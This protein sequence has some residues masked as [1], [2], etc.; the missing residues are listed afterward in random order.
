M[1][2]PDTLVDAFVWPLRLLG[3]GPEEEQQH[4]PLLD[5]PHNVLVNHM[6]PAL[7][8]KEKCH[9]ALACHLLWQLVASTATRLK[10]EQGSGTLC[11][12]ARSPRLLRWVDK[13]AGKVCWSCSHSISAI[14]T[15]RKK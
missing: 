3:L 11:I 10:F 1:Q 14:V 5:L 8:N 13:Q 9:L 4:L 2:L 12:A 15:Y 6:I 7:S